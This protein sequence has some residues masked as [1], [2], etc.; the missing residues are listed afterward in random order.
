MEIKNLVANRAVKGGRRTVS[1]ACWFC[2]GYRNSSGCSMGLSGL[3]APDSA[4]AVVGAKIL[5]DCAA[6]REFRPVK[7][8][9][10]Y[11]SE[12][13][14]MPCRAASSLRLSFNAV[15]SCPLLPG[16]G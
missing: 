13:K 5:E 6:K 1:M 10:P 14:T 8:L 3:P 11:D 16:Y 7:L 15:C 12:G 4:R 2:C 9:L